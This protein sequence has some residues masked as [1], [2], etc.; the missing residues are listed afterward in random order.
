MDE[1]EITADL[2][3]RRVV[4][5]AR[6]EWGIGTV[7]RVQSTT[8]GGQVRHRVSVQFAVGHRL[9]QVPPARLMPPERHAP[10]PAGWLD[11]L[12][13]NTPADRLR[14]LP[15]EITEFLGTAGQRIVALAALYAWT[16]APAALIAWARRQTGTAD[17]LAHWSRD[18]LLAA[19]G[20][21]CRRRDAA[22]RAAAA[23]LRESAGAA[24][25]LEALAACP[26]EVRPAMQAALA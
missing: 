6:P 26:A 20:E 2:V 10:R 9:L 25:V 8:V 4:N 18:E 14:R 19:F 13:E 12:A 7:L 21:F 15:P 22:L 17:P 3:G 11:Q 5:A 24:A 23:R 16:A 1:L